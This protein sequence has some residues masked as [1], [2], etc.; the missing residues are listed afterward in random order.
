MNIR[1][2][3]MFHRGGLAHDLHS[4]R[5]QLVTGLVNI[6][7]AERD[8]AEAVADIIRVRI[9][10]V[11]KLDDRVRLFRTIADKALVNRPDS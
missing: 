10:I 9:P 6:R 2:A 11:R 4:F 1:A 3:P 5:A 8:M 7:H